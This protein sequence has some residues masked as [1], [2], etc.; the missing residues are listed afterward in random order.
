MTRNIIDIN[1][2]SNNTPG[3]TTSTHDS[4]NK[5]PRERNN[6]RQKVLRE[7]KL[8]AEKDAILK[9]G[10][11]TGTLIKHHAQDLYFGKLY[12]KLNNAEKDSISNGLNSILDLTN[13]SVDEN[14]QRSLLEAEWLDLNKKWNKQK[15]WDRLDDSIQKKL[16][17]IENLAC[18][19]LKKAYIKALSYQIKYAL[20]DNEAFFEVYACL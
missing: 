20:T 14:S 16:K 2:E 4:S 15:N 10:K 7:K 1:I 12:H 13:N 17:S 5:E 19:S 8:P 11:S 3:I 18:I 9:S 6:K